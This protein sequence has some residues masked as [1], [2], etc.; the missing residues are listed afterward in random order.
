[1]ERAGKRHDSSLLTLALCAAAARK[2]NYEILLR[3]V[4][5]DENMCLA[6]R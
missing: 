6:R 5:E 3:N 2:E 4:I 1:M